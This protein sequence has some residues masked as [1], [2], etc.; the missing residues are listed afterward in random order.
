MP[1]RVV[2]IMKAPDG[3][4]QMS[5]SGENHQPGKLF[6]CL[7]KNSNFVSGYRFGGTASPVAL[8]RWAKV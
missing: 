4:S 8:K 1:Y 5:Y 6:N 3:L 2:V 7:L